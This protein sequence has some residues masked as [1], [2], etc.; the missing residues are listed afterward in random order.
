MREPLR[1]FTKHTILLLVLGLVPMGLYGSYFRNPLVFDDVSIF[2]DQI[3]YQIGHAGFYLTPRW[4]AYAPLGWTYSL[5]GNEWTWFRFENVVLHSVTCMLL[6]LFFRRLFSEILAEG[7][8]ASSTSIQWYAFAGA[9]LFAVHPVAVYAVGYLVERSILLATLFSV[10]FLYAYLEGMLKRNAIWF[11]VSGMFYLMAVFSKEHSVLIPGVALAMTFLLRPLRSRDTLKTLFWPFIVYMAIAALI[12][13]KAKGILGGHYEPYA[14]DMLSRLSENATEIQIDHAYGLSILT[15]GYLFFKYLFLWLLP[16]PTWMAIDIRPAFATH[17]LSWPQSVGFIGFLLW[18]V[19]AIRLMRGKGEIVLLGFAL[20]SPWL[21]FLTELST[22]RLQEPFVLYRSYLWMMMLPAAIPWVATKLRRRTLQSGIFILVSLM[23]IAVAVNRL[24]TFRS[25]LALWEDAIRTFQPGPGVLGA[26]RLYANRGYAY[27]RMGDD[28][29]ALADYAEALKINPRY[30]GALANQA[31]A[32]LRSGQLDKALQNFETYIRLNPDRA[33]GYLGRGR[34]FAAQ[35]RYNAALADFT[36]VISMDPN[37]ADGY[38]NRAN[39]EMTLGQN[40]EAM[41][42]L[43]EA[44]RLNPRAAEI[45]ATRGRLSLQLG[46]LGDAERDLQQSVQ[47]NPTLALSYSNRGLFYA[48]TGQMELAKADFDKV[49]ELQP[50]DA[51]AYFNRG[52]VYVSLNQTDKALADYDRATQLA[53][54][55]SDAHNNRGALRMMLG[56][57]PAAVKDFDNAIKFSPHNL[58]AHINRGGVLINLGQYNPAIQDFDAALALK[59]DARAYMGR[60]L[61]YL[62]LNQKRQA[63][64]D[65]RHACRLGAQGACSKLQELGA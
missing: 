65:L 10:A 8:S 53:P 12:I 48:A 52:N 26:E 11:L 15:Q 63:L 19:L 23:L 31:M 16:I 46:R 2:T 3:L 18:P 47:L 36:R 58:D 20:L 1:F 57:M 33:A 64:S 44:Q 35:K 37:I 32:Y 5:V 30:R 59:E 9:F 61:A 25:D 22:V 40:Q 41:N 49:I 60:G 27:A 7:K 42:D 4:F 55:L 34:I 14:K 50:R 17:W 29:R 24:N 45:Y 28:E 13:L 54:D 51:N 39:V 6:Y 43:D 38:L 56:N 62:G 21:L